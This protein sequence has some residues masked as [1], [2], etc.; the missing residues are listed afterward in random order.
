MNFAVMIF[1]SRMIPA[2]INYILVILLLKRGAREGWVWVGG[3]KIISWGM[4]IT[5]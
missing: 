3:K 1:K 2:G 5:E 4:H